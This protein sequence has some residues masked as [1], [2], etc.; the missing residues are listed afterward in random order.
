MARTMRNVCGLFYV[1]EEE[2]DGARVEDIEVRVL[3]EAEWR[4]KKW[5][6][7]QRGKR[8]SV[9]YPEGWGGGVYTVYLSRIEVWGMRKGFW[10]RYI[11][12]CCAV[13][14]SRNSAFH[15]DTVNT[16]CG[17]PCPERLMVLQKHRSSDDCAGQTASLLTRHLQRP[18]R[19]TNWK[20]VSGPR[21]L[22]A[23]SAGRSTGTDR[24][25]ARETRAGR[26][27]FGTE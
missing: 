14:H 7:K 13:G 8:T 27:V 15:Y 17:L 23:N 11:D 2:S 5:L 18:P 20:L 10:R 9:V 24:R 21:R 25:P 19:G 3:G 1:E 22:W 6:K 26:D 12:W 16:F 4:L